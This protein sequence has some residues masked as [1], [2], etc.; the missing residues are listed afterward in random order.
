MSLDFVPKRVIL[1]CSATPDY[2]PDNKA[3]DL[4]GAADIDSWHKQRGFNYPG[5]SIGYHKVIRQSGELEDGR[6]EHLQGAHCKGQ[7]KDTLGICIIGNGRFNHDQVQTLG[8]LYEMYNSWYGIDY[9]AWF[10]HYEFTKKKTCPNA[11]IDLVRAYF[12]LL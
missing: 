2:P 8:E 9:T 4:I 1:H 7:N 11:P 12:R 5:G 6:P 10:A 3:F